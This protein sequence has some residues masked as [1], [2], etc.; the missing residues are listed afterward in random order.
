[1][2]KALKIILIVLAS[3]IVLGIIAAMF[4]DSDNNDNGTS[5]KTSQIATSEKSASKSDE[6]PKKEVEKQT[7]NWIKQGMYKVGVDITAGE[8]IIQADGNCYYSVSS[9]SSGSLDSIVANGNTSTHAY[10]T[11]KD[12]Q[13]IEVKRGKMIESSKQPAFTA[14]DGK[15]SQGVYKVGKDI[16]AGEY[17]VVAKGNGYYS[18]SKDSSGSLS[19]IISNDNFEGE[20]YI[21]ISDGQYLVLNR[22]E[23]IV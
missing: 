20:K 6:K 7:D 14:V 16:P 5:S 9:D 13:Y 18:V 22:C 2:K 1:M 15:Y 17:K 19:S 3:I 11:V 12:G 4:S 23:L 8:Y 10:I 21:T